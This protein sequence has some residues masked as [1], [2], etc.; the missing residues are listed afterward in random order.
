MLEQGTEALRSVLDATRAIDVSA[1]SSRRP[2]PLVNVV[3]EAIE[4]TRHL[5]GGVRVEAEL[6]AMEGLTINCNRHLLVQVLVNLLRNA[7]EAIEERQPR[8][9]GWIRI[10]HEEPGNGRTTLKISDNGIGMA[11]EVAENLFKFKYTTKKDGTGI[12]LHFS[13]MI[14]KL[15]EGTIVAESTVGKGTTFRVELPLLGASHPVLA[16]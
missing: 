15:H 7:A 1:A 2:E 9:G 5:M 6:E 12:G 8:E 4:L 3:D 13:K 16:S 11:P 10:T 14:V